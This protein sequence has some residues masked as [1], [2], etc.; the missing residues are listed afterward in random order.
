MDKGNNICRP[1]TAQE[2]HGKA[3]KATTDNHIKLYTYQ[4]YVDRDHGTESNPLYK[5]GLRNQPFY[6]PLTLWTLDRR[7]DG[8]VAVASCKKGE[9]LKT[10]EGVHLC[11][12]EPVDDFAN[13]LNGATIPRPQ[14]LYF[15]TSL[16]LDGHVESDELRT[17][18]DQFFMYKSLKIEADKKAKAD[19]KLT[20]EALETEWN[21]LVE[22]LKAHRI[23]VKAASAPESRVPAEH[24]NPQPYTRPESGTHSRLKEAVF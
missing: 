4:T 15:A 21:R 18:L 16:M 13:N 6:I 19:A 10:F 22:E 1:A 2:I 17:M 23:V 9:V 3:E 12:S 7:S 20:T 5:I 11:S 14:E 24:G 8:Q